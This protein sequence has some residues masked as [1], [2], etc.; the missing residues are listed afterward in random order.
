MLNT[1]TDP[2]WN[3]KWARILDGLPFS[4]WLCWASPHSGRLTGF[5]FQ[6][7]FTAC[8]QH[9][10]LRARRKSPTFNKRDRWSPSQAVYKFTVDKR[11]TLK[12][13]RDDFTRGLGIAGL[14]S[15]QCL[16]SRG[17]GELWTEGGSGPS[18]LRDEGKG[19]KWP[20][21]SEGKDN[22]R[23]PTLPRAWAT[24][25]GK[26]PLGWGTGPE[27]CAVKSHQGAVHPQSQFRQ[28]EQGSRFTRGLWNQKVSR[29]ETFKF[30]SPLPRRADV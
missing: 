6:Q 20:A 12:A 21:A 28:R 18:E 7:V 13:L 22:P 29:S 16:E 27:R 19:V 4:A 9:G 10:L 1:R 24:P 11:D 17:G 30:I 26:P 5:L 8:L 23:P 2:I 15:H 3:I 25:Q 14:N